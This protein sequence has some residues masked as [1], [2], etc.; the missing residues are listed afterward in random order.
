MKGIDLKNRVSITMLLVGL[1]AVMAAPVNVLA[2]SGSGSANSGAKGGQNCAKVSKS[3][4]TDTGAMTVT[5]VKINGVVQVAGRDYTVRAGT[6]GSTRPVIDF[7]HPLPA[8]VD[9]SVRVNTVKAG[10]FTVDVKLEC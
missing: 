9:V 3:S 10:T 6:S 1:L 2:G 7:T 4:R 8:N 5:E